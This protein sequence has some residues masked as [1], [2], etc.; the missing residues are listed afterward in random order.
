L[1]NKSID[2]HHLKV[3]DLKIHL[4]DALLQNHNLLLNIGPLSDGSVRPED[5]ATLS[6]LIRHPGL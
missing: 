2:G 1:N 5:V 6:N 3:E 4:G